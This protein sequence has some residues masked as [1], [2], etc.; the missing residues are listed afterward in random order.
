MGSRLI[1]DLTA[2][3]QPVIATLM[4]RWLVQHPGNPLVVTYTLRSQAEQDEAVAEGRSETHHGPHLPHAPDGKSWACDLCP[5]SLIELHNYAPTS[6]F[7]WD[8]GKLALSMGLRWGGKWNHPMPPV[9]K[10]PKYFFD[11]QH[12]EFTGI[13]PS[14]PAT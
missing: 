4:A 10:I 13:S 1:S 5:F 6:P 2:D 12:C 3:F 7:W 14:A 8:L 9:G 11:P